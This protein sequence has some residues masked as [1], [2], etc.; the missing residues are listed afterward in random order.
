[1]WPAPP[2]MFVQFR[3]GGTILL[4]NSQ[5]YLSLQSRLKL[6]IVRHREFSYSLQ[7]GSRRIPGRSEQYR[8]PNLRGLQQ[9]TR[10]GLQVPVEEA[11]VESSRHR[12]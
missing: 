1:M 12:R 7:L 9:D 6:F 2:Q 10:D 5:L 11:T 3:V 4:C 8:G